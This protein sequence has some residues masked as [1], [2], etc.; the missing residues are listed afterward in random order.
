MMGIKRGF[1]DLVRVSHVVNVLFKE[2]LGFLVE[3]L[4]LKH[5]LPFHRK[6]MKSKFKRTN[7]APERLRKVFEKLGGTYVKL[8]QLLSIR[9]DLIPP[10]ISEELKKLQDECPPFPFS[11]VKAIIEKELKEP[12]ER[13]FSSF[14]EKPVAAASIA[15]V[16]YGLLKDGSEVV[17]KVQRP[18]VKSSIDEDIDIMYYFAHR[19]EKDERYKNFSPVGI[20][21]EF[22]AYTKRELDFTNEA[23]NI[24]L[25]YNNFKGY[26]GIRI[27][28]V[29][30]NYV[31]PSVLMMEFIPGKRLSSVIRQKTKIDG[32][33]TAITGFNALMKMVFEDGI[34]HADLHPGNILL[35]KKEV[36]IVDFGIVGFLDDNLRNK[37]VR[38][39]A[40]LLEKDSKKMMKI[41][42]EVGEKGDK[43]NMILFEEDLSKVLMQWHYTSP[44]M[45]KAT[46]MLHKIFNVCLANDVKMP[47]NLV[48]LGKALVT[49]E[50]TCKEIYPE[51]NVIEQAKPYL[52]KYLSKKMEFSGMIKKFI[53]RS[54]SLKESMAG[55]PERAGKLMDTLSKGKIELDVKEDMHR[56]GI[57]I[58]R[59]SNR[60]S[61]GMLIAA[62]V[63]SGALMLQTNFEPKIFH[64]PILSL[65]CFGIAMMFGIMLF[66]SIMNEGK[67]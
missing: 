26:P 14:D 47:V 49:A 18:D 63:L 60:L 30:W 52:E 67:Y 2:G 35:T 66:I 22:S 21:D 39:L 28:F 3:D 59:S 23:K 65:L 41:L 7:S 53:D 42:L 48:L 40:S 38:L 9:P 36:A 20:I 55:L 33:A 12:M 34:F 57:E 64:Y 44:D 27:P 54:G 45:S 37:A 51:F 8:G 10:E 15:Q 32:R 19:M 31:T 17:V 13:I 24:T 50:A 56:L 29:H 16:H 6:L 1:E 58:D 61:L 46:H 11:Q 43:T 62:F 25:F 5:H 4:K